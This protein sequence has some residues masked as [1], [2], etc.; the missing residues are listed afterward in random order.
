[1]D[2]ELLAPSVCDGPLWVIIVETGLE[3]RSIVLMT[4]A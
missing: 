4:Q 3:G 1:M 2:H